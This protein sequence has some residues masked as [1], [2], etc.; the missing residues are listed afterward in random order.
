M[1]LTS[2]DLFAAGATAKLG[3]PLGNSEGTK[4]IAKGAR[5]VDIVPFRLS[6]EFGNRTISWGNS[7]AGGTWQI[8]ALRRGGGGLC[9]RVEVSMSTPTAR[10]RR[11]CA[12]TPGGVVKGNIARKSF[13]RK[14]IGF[15]SVI[16]SITIA[17]FAS[18]PANSAG[19]QLTRFG[20]LLGLTVH[21]LR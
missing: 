17:L 18:K 15:K 19:L 2:V 9:I 5:Q 21:K 16:N 1:S 20:R 12:V 10:I 14:T 13:K 11:D 6:K 3:S 8:R 4:D 7:E